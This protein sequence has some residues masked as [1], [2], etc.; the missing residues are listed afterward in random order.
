MT[1]A[2]LKTFI[3]HFK[4]AFA[5]L[6]KNDPLRLAGA[7]AFFANFAIPPILI[8]LIRLFGF[9]M[10]RKTF[11]RRLFER[12]SEI[13]DESSITQI[14]NT[15]ENIRKVDQ[16]WVATMISFVFFLFVAT[17]LFSVIKSS[18]DQIWSIGIKP[19]SSFMF[20]LKLRARSMVI[21]VL[22]GF[23]FTVG[24]LTDSIQAFIGTYINE[25]APNFG[26]F[27]LAVLNQVLFIAIVTAWFTVLF[28]FLTNG[29]PSWKDALI[30]G[31]L[32]GILFTLGKYILRIMLPLSN[33]G[34]IYGTSGSVILIMLFIFY[35]SM[36]FY[37]GACFVRILSIAHESPIR[38]IKGAFVYELKE[39][40]KASS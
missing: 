31:I 28:R 40:Q 21:I 4:A 30:G 2:P 13:L 25:S 11:A 29:R 23:L 20:K 1:F 36:I 22:A 35:S 8:I 12:L 16:N 24:L 26:R 6:Q 38:P 34:S 9:F 17:T 39:V 5:L 15:L 7:T 3:T 27:L 10:D 14:R 33:I 37:F 19:H 32:T 18:M